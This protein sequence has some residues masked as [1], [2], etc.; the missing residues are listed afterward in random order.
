MKY[1]IKRRRANLAIVDREIGR[2]FGWFG[3]YRSEF[4]SLGLWARAG[5]WHYVRFEV[6]RG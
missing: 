1:D 6:K 4:V 5:R 3:W 2:T